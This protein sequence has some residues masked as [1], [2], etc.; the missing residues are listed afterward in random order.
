MSEEERD[1]LTQPPT[2][3]AADPV[4]DPGPAGDHAPRRA[5]PSVPTPGGGGKRKL[6]LWLIILLAVLLVAGVGT[7]LA[8]RTGWFSGPRLEQTSTPTPTPEPTTPSPVPAPT[9]EPLPLWPL[10]GVPGQVTQHAAIAVKIEND[11]AARPQQG[12]ESAD[13]VYEELVEGGIT[14]YLAVFHSTIPESVMPVRSIRPMDG[15]IASWTKGLMV[16]SGGQPAFANRAATDGMQLISMDYGDAGFSRSKARHAPHNVLGDM[17]KFQAQA[18]AEHQGSP[19]AFADFVAVNGFASAQTTGQT[20]RT[21]SVTMSNGARPRW[22][23]DVPS[24]SWL[25]FEGD[26]PAMVVAGSQI[27]ATNLLIIKVDVR[28]TSGRDVAG[29]SIPE[30][31]MT[32]SGEGLVAGSGMV[33]PITWTKDAETDVMRY[34][35]SK[36]EPISLLPGNTWVE[37]VPAAT[38]SYALS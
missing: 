20:F 38:G 12:I 21:V 24:R 10:T 17:A 36:G 30:S 16:F 33:A 4:P 25:R 1:P 22:T 35:D 9:P 34:F 19:P 3:T 37:L 6:R 15:P 18:D 8:W 13:I 26:Q 11:A 29:S 31:I 23:Y 2:P 28:S 5:D 14:R 27:R 7:A 32:G